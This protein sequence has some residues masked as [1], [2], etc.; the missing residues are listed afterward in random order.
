VEGERGFH[1]I[2]GKIG[3]SAHVVVSTCSKNSDR[4]GGGG[5]GGLGGGGGPS[6]RTGD[7][8]GTFLSKIG[9]KGVLGLGVRAEF[10]RSHTAH[11][12]IKEK[13]V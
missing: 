7:E 12:G 1:N 2:G 3:A 11:C 10:P 5:G 8:G 4:G 13:G 9:V 6:P